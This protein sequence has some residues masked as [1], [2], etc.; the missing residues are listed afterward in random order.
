MGD[1]F[2]KPGNSK[3]EKKRLLCFYNGNF[4]FVTIANCDHNWWVSQFQLM[5]FL[6]IITAAHDDS[7]WKNKTFKYECVVSTTNQV[8]VL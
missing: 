4:L 7:L 1:S 8:R 6:I 5:T 3:H 2:L